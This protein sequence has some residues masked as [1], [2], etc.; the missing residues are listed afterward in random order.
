MQG[1]R[2]L[3]PVALGYLCLALWAGLYHGAGKDTIRGPYGRPPCRTC[4]RSPTWTELSPAAQ[5]S[6]SAKAPP[7]QCEA[8]PWASGWNYL[9]G[10]FGS[11]LLLFNLLNGRI[12]QFIWSYLLSGE[13]QI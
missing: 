6:R 8:G 1:P 12:Y 5:L 2:C 13:N 9:F 11:I 7:S 3:G 4:P 10:L